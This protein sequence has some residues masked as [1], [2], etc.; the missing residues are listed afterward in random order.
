[1]PWD[2]D[3]FGVIKTRNQMGTSGADT[4]KFFNFIPF[5][6]LTFPVHYTVKTF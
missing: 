1:M 5:Q 3:M 4:D 6:Y 2:S